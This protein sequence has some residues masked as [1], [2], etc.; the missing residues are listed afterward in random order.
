MTIDEDENVDVSKPK[1]AAA[2]LTGVRVA[3]QRSVSQMGFRRTTRPCSSSM[4][5]DST[6]TGSNTPTSKSVI[7]SL[8]P[9]GTAR[10]ATGARPSQDPVGSDE[11][12]KA[13]PEPPQLS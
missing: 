10:P 6:A 1:K 11:G 8:V 3:L 12:H 9:A 4:P 13:R 5:L 7:V 2:G